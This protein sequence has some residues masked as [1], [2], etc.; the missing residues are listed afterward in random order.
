MLKHS[1]LPP[2]FHPLP[3]SLAEHVILI[4]GAG[5]GLG[6][7]AALACAAA[8]AT[9]ILHGREIGK[10]ETVYDEITDAGGHTPAL[11]PLDFAKATQTDLNSFRE[12]IHQTFGRLDGLFHAATYFSP[13]KPIAETLVT[14]WRSHLDVNVGTP[15]ALTATLIPLLKQSSHGAVVFLTETHALT[16]TPFWGAFATAKSALS[17]LVSM[18]AAENNTVRFNLCLPGPVASPCRSLS[19]PGESALALA[20]PAS[21]AP[22]FVYLLSPVSA[23]LC[24]ALH[25]C[26]Q[27]NPPKSP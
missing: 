6:R 14:E 1:T 5:Q 22:N 11:M 8:G 18:L 12:A 3:S 27:Q 10:L 7:A 9:I 20:T 13:L 2:D 19:H 16:P 24:D 15:A 26:T 23:P 21:L 4:T 25:I 17:S